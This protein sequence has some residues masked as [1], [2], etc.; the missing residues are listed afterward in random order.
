MNPEPNCIEVVLAA[1]SSACCGVNLAFAGIGVSVFV[2][3][4]FELWRFRRDGRELRA[5]LRLVF[6]SLVAVA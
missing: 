6:P 1:E 5:H 4:G 2:D 3:F